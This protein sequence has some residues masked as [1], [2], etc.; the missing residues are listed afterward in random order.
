M[1]AQSKRERWLAAA[2]VASLSITGY[3]A[4]KGHLAGTDDPSVSP[5][6]GGGGTPTR[7]GVL[8]ETAPA[9]TATARQP[10][11][12]LA[13]DCYL[14]VVVANESVDVVAEVE[15]RV[16]EILLRSGEAVE[17][18]A[19]L[20]VLDNPSLGHQ[21]TVEH[22]NL[23]LIE[24]EVKSFTVQ[25]ERSERLHRRR[26]DLEGLISRE[27]AEAFEAQLE[28]ARYRL[29]VAYAE[30]TQ[31]NARIA[32]LETRLERTVIRA[33]FTGTVSM[34][35]L[36]R[37]AVVARGTPVVKLITGDGSR[38][39][40]AVPPPA[41]GEPV[42]GSR[43]RVEIE[44]LGQAVSGVVEH[45]APEIDAAS[46]MIFVE[47]RLDPGM[48]KVPPGAIARVSLVGPRAEATSCL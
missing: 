44:G 7:V 15:G 29:D 3:L 23:A 8:P 42:A 22:G 40:F 11:P 24:A 35:Y 48:S 19:R 34:R 46:A 13:S 20:A 27:D 18:G 17:R 37:G 30:L 12:P 28:L 43:V 5:Q 33:P 21:L 45:R 41:T 32:D 39:R 4:A 9:G 26:L 36:D 10:A 47:S 1:S 25:L 14:G 6:E 16:R 31:V 38:V 2:L